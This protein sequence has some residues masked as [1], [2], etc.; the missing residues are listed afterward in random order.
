MLKKLR[1]SQKGFTL[2]ELLI[3]IAL[4]G[5]ISTAAAVSIHQ[6]ITGTTLSNNQNTAI[7]QVRN[8]GYWISRD[9][10]MAE[11]IHVGDNPET[12]LTINWTKYNYNGGDDEYHAIVYSLEDI[13]GDR[14]GKLKRTHYVGIPSTEQAFIADHIY[15]NPDES[16][17][18]SAN[19]TSPVLT[20]QI[21]A[22]T[23]DATETREYEITRRPT[24]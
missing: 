1:E 4:T 22:K 10:L 19:Y 13:S 9:A 8:A 7:N 3:V 18:T 16:N 17:T 14:I 11:N 20:V 15:Y 6:V 12:F 23:E 5:I 2:I 21:T 24:F